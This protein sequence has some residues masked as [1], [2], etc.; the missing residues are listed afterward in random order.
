MNNN[1]LKNLRLA[2]GLTQKAVS[3]IISLSRSAYTKIENGNTNLDITTAEKLARFY[4]VSL[5]RLTGNK[6]MDNEN[7]GLQS[8]INETKNG[9]TLEGHIL[10]VLEQTQEN[11]FLEKASAVPFDCLTWE[12]KKAL[13]RKGIVTKEEYTT[14]HLGGRLYKVGYKEIFSMMMQNMGMSVFFRNNLITNSHWMKRWED[15]Q[16]RL[17]QPI[18]HG[19]D[20]RNPE[21][22]EIDERVYF[23]VILILLT[24]PD[25][26]TE[27]VQI[28]ERDFP[29]EQDLMEYVVMKCG[30]VSGEFL[31]STEDGYDP[32]SKIVK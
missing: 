15:Y 5:E 13:R 10:S 29:K 20:S 25:E 3:E 24:M 22:Y 23:Y 9:Q 4:K 2:K 14:P 19:K 7:S 16:Q 12:Q 18:V 21:D 31:A 8:Q 27:L 6:N 26:E 11:L 28:A 17:N 30:A 1:E 32:F